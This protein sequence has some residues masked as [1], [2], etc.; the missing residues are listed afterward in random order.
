MP[1]PGDPDSPGNCRH[2]PIVIV[3]YWDLHVPDMKFDWHLPGKRITRSSIQRAARGGLQ[4]CPGTRS[5]EAERPAADRARLVSDCE[6][7]DN[8]ARLRDQLGW[9]PSAQPSTV[10]AAIRVDRLEA[11]RMRGTW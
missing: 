8:P 10:P 4:P 7:H 6:R 9:A 3:R 2:R 1:V 11:D 5:A